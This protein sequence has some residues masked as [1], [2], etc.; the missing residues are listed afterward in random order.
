MSIV[1]K[2]PVNM[3]I[4]IKEKE[5]RKRIFNKTLNMSPFPCNSSFDSTQA[6]VI[7]KKRVLDT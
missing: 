2:L 7:Q 5:K 6:K 4:Y 1:F 3:K